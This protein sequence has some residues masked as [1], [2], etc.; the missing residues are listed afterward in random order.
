MKST[1]NVI[2]ISKVNG[3]L[4]KQKKSYIKIASIWPQAVV[5]IETSVSIVAMITENPS[6]LSDIQVSMISYEWPDCI[7]IFLRKKK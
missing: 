5:D 6:A 1:I 3:K 7:S 4:G 2:I